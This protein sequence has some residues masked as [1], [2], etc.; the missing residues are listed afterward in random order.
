MENYLGHT[1]D[2]YGTVKTVNNG[3]DLVITAESLQ[4]K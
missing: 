1:V 2:V 4:L 3:N